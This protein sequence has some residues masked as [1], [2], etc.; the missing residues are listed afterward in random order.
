[1]YFL[2]DAI[3]KV[4][5]RWSPNGRGDDFAQFSRYFEQLGWRPLLSVLSAASLFLFV[6]TKDRR[7]T[8]HGGRLRDQSEAGA[9][10]IDSSTAE[11]AKETARERVF[12]DGRRCVD[13]DSVEHEVKQG[14]IEQMAVEAS[15]DHPSEEAGSVHGARCRSQS[16]ELATA[17]EKFPLEGGAILEVVPCL[18]RSQDVDTTGVEAQPF[19]EAK[20][21]EDVDFLAAQTD[22]EDVIRF[23]DGAGMLRMWR[24][25]PDSHLAPVS[26]SEDEVEWE[27]ENTAAKSRKRA[28]V[29]KKRKL[30]PTLNSGVIEGESTPGDQKSGV[31]SQDA[32][33]E[34]AQHP[35][36]EVAQE[37]KCETEAP[38]RDLKGEVS[39][40]LRGLQ[41]NTQLQGEQNDDSDM[42][43]VLVKDACSGVASTTDSETQTVLEENTVDFL[44]E[45]MP[46]ENVVGQPG[47]RTHVSDLEMHIQTL[48]E[49]CL[50][51]VSMKE[52]IPFPRSVSAPVRRSAAALSQPQTLVSAPR[53]GS[54][55][56]QVP[57]LGSIFPWPSGHDGQHVSGLST[58][59]G[60]FRATTS[61]TS[62][63]SVE[64]FSMSTPPVSAP[65][66]APHTPRLHIRDRMDTQ[67]AQ[68]TTLSAPG[69]V[70]ADL[71]RL[72]RADTM[73][74][75]TPQRSVQ[76]S[77]APG[78]ACVTP[79]RLFR[80]QTMPDSSESRVEVS[81]PCVSAP[82]AVRVPPRRLS[83]SQTMPEDSHGRK[84]SS[85]CI[86]AHGSFRVPRRRLSHSQTMSED[87]HGS[88]VEPPSPCISAP[89]SVRVPLGR[90]SHSQA[91]SEDPHGRKVEPPSPCISAP[92][93]VRVPLMTLSRSHSDTMPYASKQCQRG[94]TPLAPPWAP[95][96][97]TPMVPQHVE[98]MHA[99][100]LSPQQTAHLR[101]AVPTCVPSPQQ[102]V[103]PRV[104]PGVASV[105]PGSATPAHIMS[106]NSHNWSAPGASYPAEAGG[107]KAANQILTGASPHPGSA[108]GTVQRVNPGGVRVA[109]QTLVVQGPSHLR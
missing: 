18:S 69:S 34:L 28:K 73:P 63:C 42:L 55:D 97:A 51:E 14:T 67:S 59:L 47:L 19:V 7:S 64:F 1:M 102:N 16:S 26:E 71:G 75:Y 77:S 65:H 3:L 11:P 107:Y 38:A 103:V 95:P 6:V 44:G 12:P 50:E 91:M 24:K 30:D 66:S 29:E 53:G 85:P 104:Q 72:R 109:G 45:H 35:L 106:T 2:A 93:S 60:S 81:S 36:E 54:D 41:D 86:S 39:D 84:L 23:S 52:T 32:Q 99:A 88:K 57:K 58:P 101:H 96:S 105:R 79:Q 48:E 9:F 108:S 100:P 8:V 10:I 43:A 15:V 74:T 76:S 80:S 20:L 90:L 40:E 31:S 56:V 27:S 82:G 37:S 4:P 68:R 89:G 87:P 17:L 92:G 13:V 33:M 62:D 22:L 98:R 61:S 46:H 25:G 70:S 21:A 49:I 94:G 78:S 5:L 83:H